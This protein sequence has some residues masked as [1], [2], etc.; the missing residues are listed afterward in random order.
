MKTLTRAEE[1]VMQV[2]W[3]LESALVKEIVAKMKSPKPHYN[4]VSTIVTI[5]VE[6]GFASYEYYGRS[7]E[8]YPLVSKEDYAKKLVKEVL[9]KYYGNSFTNLAAQFSSERT[10]KPGEIEEI[11]KAAKQ[12]SPK[13]KKRGRKKKKS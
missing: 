10:F 7:Y 6:K 11:A 5:L 1:E 12:A 2:L 4:T 8:Y 9:R 3:K 13:P